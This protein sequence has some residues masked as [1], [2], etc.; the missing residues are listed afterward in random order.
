MRE[1]KKSHT[2]TG[3]ARSQEEG[4]GKKKSPHTKR[5]GNFRLKKI[6]YEVVVLCVTYQIDNVQNKKWFI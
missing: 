2:E 6:L 5:G 1:K 3:T 4:T